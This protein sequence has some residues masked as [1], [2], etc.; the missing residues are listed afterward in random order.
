MKIETQNDLDKLITDQVEENLHLDYKAADALAKSDGK[1]KE[2][3][4]DISAL[5]NS[6]GGTIIYGIKEFSDPNKKHLPEL[7]DPIDRTI[8][9][10]EWIE[11][12]I[13]GNISP[14]IPDIKIVP[15]PINGSVDK[16]VYVVEVPK[17]QTAHQAADFRYY[18]RNNFESVPMYDYE[19][20]DIMNR[21]KNPKI[22]L[23]FKI[24][25]T[26]YTPT[27]TFAVPGIGQ[28]QP[29]STKLNTLVVRGKN[30]GG[31]YA[32]YVS[33]HVEVPS[34]IL[35]NS[36]DHL[37]DFNKDGINYKSIYCDNTIRELFDVKVGVMGHVDTKYWP[38]RYDPI[39]P[40]TSM[41][42]TDISLVQNQLPAD[43]VIYWTLNADNAERLEGQINLADIDIAS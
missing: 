16:V 12:I 4:K 2:V 8:F 3:S 41:N 30:V 38:S 21:N 23:T 33:C 11:Q 32:N 34:R 15:I 35:G 28:Q 39:L 31:V 36:Y 20:R 43:G 10:K 22:E 17:S 26:D 7:I 5:A 24:K 29:K 37:K 40:G 27:P 42:L 13:N 19:V 25:T 18:K 6:D 1:K 9:S 14:R